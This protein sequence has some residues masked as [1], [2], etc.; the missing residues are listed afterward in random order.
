MVELL[1]QAGAVGA[2]AEE[3]HNSHYFNYVVSCEQAIS[4]SIHLMTCIA[5]HKYHMRQ[6]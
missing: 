4:T 5:V 2:D 3:K 1:G 6:R